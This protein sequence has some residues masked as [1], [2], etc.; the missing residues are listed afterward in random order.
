MVQVD[1]NLN[2]IGMVNKNEMFTMSQYTGTRGHPLKLYKKR[3]R[4]KGTKFSLY[5]LGTV[6]I[7][8]RHSEFRH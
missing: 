1:K 6:V 4:L 8:Q 7:L 2:D 3:L 5:G